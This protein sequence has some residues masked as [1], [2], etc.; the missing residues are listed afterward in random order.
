MDRLI[1]IIALFPSIILAAPLVDT[2]PPK[3]SASASNLFSAFVSLSIELSGFP[4]Y[5]GMDPRNFCARCM[6][7]VMRLLTV[8]RKFRQP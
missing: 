3:E 6:D 7:L 5:A 1:P 4:S 8:I 2:T